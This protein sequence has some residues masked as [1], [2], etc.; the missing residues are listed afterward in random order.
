VKELEHPPWINNNSDKMITQLMTLPKG[1]TRI[2]AEP[3][4]II[5]EEGLREYARVY[6]D[7]SVMDERSGCAFMMGYREMNKYQFL[8]RRRS[9]SY[10]Q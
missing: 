1:S 8:M 9:P 2:R 3:E 7:G 10:R 4:T 6:K 5:E